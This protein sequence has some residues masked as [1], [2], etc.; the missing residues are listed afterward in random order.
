MIVVISGSPGTGKTAV[1]L[2]LSKLT[3]MD[4]LH[5]SSFVL[6][7]GLYVKYDEAR[8]SYEIDDETVAQEL[9]KFLKD[10]KNIVIET[11][12]PSLINNA[13]RVVV[14]RRDPRRLFEELSQ[15]GWSKLK[16]V[17][18]VEAE[19]LGYVSTEA[20]EWFGKV[21]EIDTTNLSVDQVV[22]K[23]MNETCDHDIDWLDRQDIQELLFYL[24][25]I[26]N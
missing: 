20:K 16:I 6:E 23:I 7:K 26:I 21:C 5:V 10:R 19:I 3:G 18:N 1:S 9:E 22:G 15:R 8:S 25:K 14:L 24:D 13:D 4:Y 12:Y 17:E 11:V 2:A